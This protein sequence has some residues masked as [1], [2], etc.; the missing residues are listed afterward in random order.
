MTAKARIV[1][2]GLVVGACVHGLLQSGLRRHDM[3]GAMLII[4][5]VL[6]V[7]PSLAGAF[8]SE[9]AIRTQPPKRAV[10]RAHHKEEL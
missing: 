3:H 9:H 8:G 6:L 7:G 10:D 4:A 2:F 5:A 1:I